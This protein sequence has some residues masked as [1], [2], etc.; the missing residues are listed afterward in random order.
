MTERV[1]TERKRIN[2][3]FTEITRTEYW[4]Q[5]LLDREQLYLDGVLPQAPSPFAVLYTY[6]NIFDNF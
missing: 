1:Y 5:P 3:I 2:G 6:K 4:T